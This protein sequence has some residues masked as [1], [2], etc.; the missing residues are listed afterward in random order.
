[1]GRTAAAYALPAALVVTGWLGLEQP[2]RDGRT[3]VL[4]AL[5][6]LLPALAP[7]WPRRAA[8]LAGA[9]VVAAAVA[10]G[11][12]A[13]ALRPRDG[14]AFFAPLL[15][16]FV[17]GFL[18]FYDVA[19]PFAPL[20]RP[21]MGGVV[22]LAIF[23]FCAGLA[24]AVAAR[25][26]LAAALVLVA[27]ASWPATL[28]GGGTLQRGGLILA[29]TLLLLAVARPRPSRVY[30]HTA[31][32]VA[33]LV[34]ASLAAATSPAVAKGEFVAWSDWDVYDRP[35]DPVG[36][37]YVWNANYGGIS[38]PKKRTTVL[39]VEGPDRAHYWRAT[40]L[41]VFDGLR[42]REHVPTL[43]AS[44][45][46][47]LL[48]SDPLLP[49]AARD[50]RNWLKTDVSVEALR[51]RRL[52][53]P[54]MPVAYDPRG[55]GRLEYGPG[56]VATLR[57]GLARE[58]EYTVW[59]YTPNPT[60]A[61]LA[62]AS[63]ST[64][65][66]RSAQTQ[67]LEVLAG[68]ETPPFAYPRRWADIGR[69]YTYSPRLE[70]YRPLA[71]EARRVA[72][73]ARSAYAAAVAL[74][75]FFR[76]SRFEY[77]EQPPV[78]AGVPPLVSFVTGHRRGY[79]QQFAGAMALMLRYLG[80]PARVAAGFTS[81][82][83]DARARRWTVTDHDAHA[84]V[85][86]WFDGWGWLPFDPTPGRGRLSGAYTTASRNFD[87]ASVAS[88]MR[89]LSRSNPGLNLA[90]GAGREAP[91]RVTPSRDLPGD[92]TGTAARGGDRSA[93]LL[94]LL[95][96]VAAAL[97]AA[98]ALAKAVLRRSRYLTRDPRRVAAA[99]RSE[100]VDILA[101]QR[102]A[103]P[104]GATLAELATTVRARLGV[105]ARPFQVAAGAARFAPPEEA[106][107]AARR[108]RREL[109]RLRRSIRRRL[110]SAQRLRGL[111]SVRSLGLSG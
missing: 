13:A 60:P 81:G 48:T 31:V 36:V 39:R 83:Y 108:A 33:L 54:S 42:W 74:E 45:G 6:A 70:A 94:R 58:Q 105:D 40:T 16:R 12:P 80:V 68:L 4:L 77:D 86:V 84:W 30:R 98:I 20:E 49:E 9:A 85:E 32:A 89:S 88:I 71:D 18:D 92:L 24:L 52:P 7:T 103:V 38:F 59:S 66:R 25:R 28:V 15:S 93:S 22:L 109:R 61:Q 90:P 37:R 34:V 62:R 110:T 107:S 21:L 63:T 69:L 17:E 1:M 56:N 47:K 51:D 95:A 111:L 35:Q 75:A 99:C 64:T 27:G 73:G 78:A 79:C 8:A 57:G 43:A 11:V 14:D 50:P 2:I 44:S 26:A 46:R 41:D 3:A 104:A 100:L 76:S 10:L 97:A 102:I 101:D 82:S 19:V 65:L 96:L 67:Y 55:I 29:A 23:G 106:A 91:E 72:G 87:Y 53:A 5:L